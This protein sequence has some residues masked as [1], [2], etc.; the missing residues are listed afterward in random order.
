V[1]DTWLMPLNLLAPVVPL[2]SR[3]DSAV[4]RYWPKLDSPGHLSR[5]GEL[6]VN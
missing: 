5:A 1:P 2:S 6:N 4:T 3:F